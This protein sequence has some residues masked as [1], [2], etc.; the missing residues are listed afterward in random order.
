M[1]EL[2]KGGWCTETLT[3]CW[4]S[5]P[6]G[7]EYILWWMARQGNVRNFIICASRIFMHVSNSETHFGEDSGGWPDGTG[8]MKHTQ[9][10]CFQQPWSS[11]CFLNRSQNDSMYCCYSELGWDSN[12]QA[13][14]LFW[15]FSIFGL[16]HHHLHLV[17]A[18]F[19]RRF[20]NLLIAMCLLNSTVLAVS[21]Q[22][23]KC[24]FWLR[25]TGKVSQKHSF[26]MLS[27]HF[28]IKVY[29]IT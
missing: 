3:Q 18:R 24:C 9:S 27:N 7:K 11:L 28:C 26:G 10:R 21:K 14:T 12:A 19:R 1:Q 13:A 4:T 8:D 6:E 5:F 23:K 20:H 2:P 16:F 15:V 17:W 22:K 25:E 29:Q